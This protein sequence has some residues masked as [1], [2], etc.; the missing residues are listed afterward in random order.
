MA[1]ETHNQ[2]GELNMTLLLVILLIVNFRL[3]LAP[4]DGSSVFL[5]QI[6]NSKAVNTWTFQVASL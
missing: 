2:S 1:T 4:A 6:T 3:G 5:N